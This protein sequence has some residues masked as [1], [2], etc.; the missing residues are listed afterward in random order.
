MTMTQAARLLFAGL[1]FLP[2]AYCIITM[3]YGCAMLA[4][5]R[6]V[7]FINSHHPQLLG[8]LVGLTG[9]LWLGIM[10][11]VV[12]YWAL[13]LLFDFLCDWIIEPLQE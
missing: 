12:T 2:G 3:V 10:F 5:Q 7:G 4:A 11:C 1:L 6:W 8:C 9:I 13:R